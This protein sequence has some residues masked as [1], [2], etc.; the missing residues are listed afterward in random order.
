VESA[1]QPFAIVGGRREPLI[2]FEGHYFDRRLSGEAR[3]RARAEGIASPVAGAVANPPAQAARWAMLE[4]AA[5]IDLKAA[6]ESVSW[7]LG[8]VMGAHWQALGYESV[9][10]LA[11]DARS[12]VEGQAR[13]MA[14]FIEKA[15]LIGA[16]RRH[17]WA[18]FARGYNG[19]AYAANAYDKKIAAAYR[20][21]AGL[22]EAADALEPENA[23]PAERP[24]LLMRGMA[25][26]EVA[27]LQRQLT[28]LGYPA[29]P[30][31]I[32]GSGTAH[33]VTRFQ[34]EHRLGADGIVG[35]M[36]ARALAE[37]LSALSSRG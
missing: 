1:G 3:A 16:M 27:D 12:G 18:T 23:K 11:A 22:E 33:A 34:S 15:G 24:A 29:E 17:D 28:T 6:Y 37:A 25:G 21:Y 31:G 7:G 35:P 20:R 8:Q 13:L 9:E 30:D 26:A 5:A 2:R 19:P 36:T 14:R 10:A 4:R 32:F